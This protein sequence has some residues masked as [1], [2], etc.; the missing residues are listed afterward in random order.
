LCAEDAGLVFVKTASVF[1]FIAM[2]M[3]R[4][5]PSCG[6][7]ATEVFACIKRYVDAE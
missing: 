4:E 2:S 1:A 3:S 6:G 5:F 7:V